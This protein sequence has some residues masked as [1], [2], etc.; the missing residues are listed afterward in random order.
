MKRNREKGR[1]TATTVAMLLLALLLQHHARAQTLR[2]FEIVSLQPNELATTATDHPRNDADG[3]LMAIVRMRSTHPDDNLLE[4]VFNFGYLRHEVVDKRQELNEVWVYVQRNAK[5]ISISRQGFAPIVNHDL[6]FTIEAGKTYEMVVAPQAV[7]EQTQMVRFNVR[8]ADAK[9]VVMVSSPKNGGAEEMFGIVETGSVAKDLSLGTYAYRIVAD[10]NMYKETVGQFTISG[11]Q[12]IHVEEVTLQPNFG[13]VT[14]AVD[15]DADIYVNGKLRGKRRW[16]G[17][18]KAGNYTVEC[19]QQNHRS[20]SQYV[21]VAENDRLDIS[22]TPPEPITGSLS[23]TSQP[24]DAQ[25]R[26]DGKDYGLTPRKVDLVIGQ[27]SVTL[28]KS[29]YRD[30]SRNFDILENQT[31]RLEI[32]LK[33]QEQ[34]VKPVV[35]AVAQSKTY[36][37]NGV[38]FKMVYVEGGTFQMGATSEQGSDAYSWEKPTHQVTL[39]SFSIGETEVTQELWEAVMGS[40]PSYFTGNSQRPVEEVSWNDCQTFITKLNA[41]TGQTF[42]LPTEAEWEYAARGGNQSKGYKYSGSNTIGDVAWYWYNIPSQTS[43]TAGYGTQPV[44]TKSPNELGLYDMSGNVWEWCSDAWYSYESS[45]QTNPT[46]PGVSGSS[47]VYRGGGWYDCAGRCR[48]SIRNYD[49]P[50][51][52]RNYLGLRLAL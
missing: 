4:Y 15:A 8:P 20:S 32:D 17:K 7:A 23:L 3:T 40:N 30:E 28:S 41:L 38:Q 10:E 33:R 31:T 48:V 50:T 34:E 5:H 29:G 24:L 2:H 37:A 46:H 42:R 45:S 26:I 16:Q 9:A 47:R 11:Q 43:G 25:V 36:T 14:L 18:L 21:S 6:G 44:G 1:T 12:E 19:R 51:Y 27:H 52:T 13:E 39:S 49:A 22:L 35:P